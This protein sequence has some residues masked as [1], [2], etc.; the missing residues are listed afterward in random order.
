MRR[1][2]KRENVAEAEKRKRK[3]KKNRRR[4][5]EEFDFDVK[6]SMMM[7]K[8]SLMLLWVMAWRK[9]EQETVASCSDCVTYGVTSHYLKALVN[10]L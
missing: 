1:E 8:K 2:F 5:K 10:A 7:V 6:R 3:R 4:K 9:W